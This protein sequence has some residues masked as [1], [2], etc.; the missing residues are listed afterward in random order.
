[1]KHIALFILMF[2]GLI[3][4][5]NAQPIQEA[6]IQFAAG[7]TGTSLDGQIKGTEIVDYLIGAAAGQRL[8]IDFST[9]NLS[10]YFN[11]LPD[12][13]PTALH[14]GSV[15]GNSYDGTLLNSGDY[16][17]RVYLM[18]N[19]ARRGEVANYTIAL[20]IDGDPAPS[21]LARSNED[22]KD[23]DY[24]DGLSGGPDWWQV[25]GVPEGDHLN[26]R[27]GP[28]TGNEVV[29]RL[30]NGDRITN[31]GCQMS[32]ATKWCQ[33]GRADRA[34]IGW[35][36]G[37][38]LEEAPAP[39]ANNATGII[40]CAMTIDQPTGSCSFRV[41]RG[42]GGTASVWISLPNGGER[43][44]D[45]REGELVGSDPGMAFG[46]NRQG[47]LNMINIGAGERY[48]IP[49]AVIYGG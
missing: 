11:L 28:G 40:P 18:R 20:S 29:G 47:D 26:V 43:Y 1:M 17:I 3:S 2:A 27:A 38:Y 34:A 14:I 24:A 8:K 15:S 5:L 13:D 12:S 41:S 31:L 6:R 42:T 33:I 23:P 7:T 49:D 45:F 9:D 10:A 46:Q 4:Q 37:R 44:L 21:D 36:S 19:A 25:T 30:Y 32:G 16:R 48:E 35:A 22:T 39:G